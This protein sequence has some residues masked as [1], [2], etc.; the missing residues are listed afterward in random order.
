MVKPLIRHAGI[1]RRVGE[2]A[3]LLEETMLPSDWLIKNGWVN[4]AGSFAGPGCV[5]VASKN[6]LDADRDGHSRY[7]KTLADLLGVKDSVGIFKWNDYICPNQE[8]AVALARQAEINCGLRPV[9]I[10][11]RIE[12]VVS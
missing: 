12:A 1:R 5:M 3:I 8:T 11:Q 7:I 4:N 10:D 6:L 2:A 9:E